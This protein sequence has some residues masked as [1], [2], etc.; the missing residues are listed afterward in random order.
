V[1]WGGT[2]ALRTWWGIALFAI[3]IAG[4]MVA[5]LRQLR[6]ELESPP[7]PAPGGA[8]IAGDEVAPETGL[9]VR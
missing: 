4:G 8:T 6:D 1:L 3:L 9:A 2:H 7:E 5:L